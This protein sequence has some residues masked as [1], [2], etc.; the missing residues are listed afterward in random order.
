MHTKQWHFNF[1]FL[2]SR[3]RVNLYNSVKYQTFWAHDGISVDFTSRYYVICFSHSMGANMYCYVA[4]A[5]EDRRMGEMWLSPDDHSIQG[6]W[7]SLSWYPFRVCLWL[8]R[9]RLFLWFGSWTDLELTSPD[10][11]ISKSTSIQKC[12]LQ[13]S[14]GWRVDLIYLRNSAV[15]L[16]FSFRVQK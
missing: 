9:Y 2:V 4:N 12:S 11:Q 5:Q 15:G 3:A 16:I 14:R 6:F 1:F 7:I 10:T 13:W 8:I